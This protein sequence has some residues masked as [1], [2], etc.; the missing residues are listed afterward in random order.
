MAG[1]YLA[2]RCD[3]SRIESPS[4]R[5]SAAAGEG[6]S[7]PRDLKTPGGA[8]QDR[9]LPNPPEDGQLEVFPEAIHVLEAD[10]PQPLA[11][12]L[13]RCQDVG[14]PV[15]PLQVLCANLLQGHFLPS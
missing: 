5:R 12:L 10:V 9:R 4:A 6:C 11:L 2:W 13:Q 15:G 14:R 1:R 3:P 7:F 8:D